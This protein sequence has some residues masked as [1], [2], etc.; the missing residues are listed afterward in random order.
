MVFEFF[1]IFQR[2]LFTFKRYFSH[3][4]VLFY[5]N[6]VFF[7]KSVCFFFQRGCFFS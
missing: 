6:R 4:F 3:W 7:C 5:V 2:G 1:L